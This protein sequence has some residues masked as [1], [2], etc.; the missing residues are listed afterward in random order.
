M[1]KSAQN[2]ELEHGVPRR[3]L[4][5]YRWFSSQIQDLDPGCFAQVMA[6]GVISNA[7]FLMGFGQM[8]DVMFDINLVACPG[9]FIL[10]LLRSLFFPRRLWA[11]LTNPYRT[12]AFFTLV[13][14]TNVIAVGLDLRA[15]TFVPVML[16]IFSFSLWLILI[17]FCFAVLA[18]TDTAAG[19]HMVHGGWLLAIVATQSPV[20]S[21][22]I[23]AEQVGPLGPPVL[24]LLHMLWGIGLGLYGVLVVLLFSRIFY[25]TLRPEDLN[26]SLW[27]AMGAAAITTN[28]GSILILAET[29]LPYFQHMRSFI[30]GVTLLMWTWATWWIPI[31]LLLGIWKHLICRAP[32]NYTPA[33][34]S[35]VFP[36]G[37]YALATQRFS[38]AS[39]FTAFQSISRVIVWV[40]LGVWAATAA[41]LLSAL[42][43]RLLRASSSP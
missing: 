21:G 12:F 23:V 31:L 29:N 5:L 24:V 7:F 38:L 4:R 1:A 19:A 39:H 34:W 40:A 20:T 32:L 13:A 33:L 26:P 27:I 35:L 14:A 37:M 25:S 43:R 41:G 30:D 11:D 15:Q 36:I 17:N 10:L 18:F 2:S 8:S 16:W 42:R 9:F 28:A 6:T 22:Q 3:S